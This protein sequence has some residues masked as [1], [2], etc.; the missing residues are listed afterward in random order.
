MNYLAQL[1]LRHLWLVGR[2]GH[3]DTPR[4]DSEQL[5][6][7]LPNLEYLRIRNYH[8]TFKDLVFIAKHMSRLQ[9]L[10][11]WVQLSDWPS[12][13]ELFLLPLTPS[14]SYLRFNIHI[15]RDILDPVEIRFGLSNNMLE[16]IASG[17]HALWPKGLICETRRRPGEDS[18]A[19][20]TARI[21]EALK[22]MRDADERGNEMEVMYQTYPRKHIQPWF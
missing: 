2:D 21:N 15:F 4:W 7:A 9:Q 10:S 14:P 6:L 5:A 11:L 19:L 13:D 8:F 18:E 12:V 16:T 20:C 22:R 17:L 1:P 3:Y